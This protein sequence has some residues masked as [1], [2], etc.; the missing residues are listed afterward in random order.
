MHLL[1]FSAISEINYAIFSKNSK[2]TKAKKKEQ[3]SRAIFN[4]DAVYF[5]TKNILHFHAQLNVQIF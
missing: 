3:Q 5:F 1:L 4:A 2:S